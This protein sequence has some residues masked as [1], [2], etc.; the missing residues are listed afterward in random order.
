MRSFLWP[1]AALLVLPS[2]GGS[3][4]PV[5][6]PFGIDKRPS[7]PTCLAQPRP[8]VNTGV[9]LQRQWSTLTFQEPIFLL[10]APGD[11]NQWFVVQREGKVR[12]FAGNATADGQVRD[13]ASITVNS[14]GE[15]GLLGM[16]FHPQWPTRREVYLYYTRTPAAGDPAPVCTALANPP[17]SALISVISRFQ[18]NDGTRLDTAPDEILNVGQPYTNH[19]GGTIE[20]GLDGM[21][22]LGLGDGGAG[23]DPCGSGQNKNSLLGKMLRFDVNAPKGMY[24]IPADNPLAGV[25]GARGEIWSYGHRN[26][27]RWHFDR[28]SGDLWVGDVGQTTWEE[29]DRVVKGGNYGWN[30]C[31]GFHQRGSTTTLCNTPGLSDP[32]VEHPRSEAQSITGGAVYRGSAMPSLVGTYIY[33]DYITGTIWALT[34]DASNKPVPRP[35]ASVPAST[36]VAFGQGNDGEIYTVQITGTISK[37]VPSGAQPPDSFPQLLSQTG[38]VDPKDPTRPAPG[39]IPYDVAAPLWSDGADKQ[40][41]FAIPDGKTITIN[42]DNDWDLPIGSVAMK[43]FSVGGKRVETRLFMRHDD[44]GW[45]GYTYEWNDD[46]KDATLL[47][48]NKLKAL[49]AGATW[50]YPSRTQCIQCH[51]Q[52]AGGT[53]GLETAQLNRDFVYASTNRRS[54]QLA[55]LDHLGMFSAPLPE[56]PDALPQL[57][58]PAGKDPLEARARSYLHG[59]CSHCHRPNGGGQGTMD[60]R[61]AQSL[62]DTSTCNAVNT[63][64]MVG[65][66]TQ[67]IAPGAP[68]DSIVS[69]RLHAT[70]S[71]RM[72]PVA[73][74]IT[75]PLGTKLIDDWIRSL[76]ACP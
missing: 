41:Y 22:Y 47:P 75:D 61:Y 26:P 65:T 7:N 12:A 17:A 42:P 59:N 71:K 18:S 43:T 35:I 45:A 21:L 23:D 68:Q 74:T 5:A 72:P 44:G 64:G 37:L 6:A 46:G 15:G 16:A 2:C 66:A 38:C 11:N 3:D 70:D 51:S 10:Q 69:L 56:P 57:S 24:N 58:D 33:G 25:A 34:Y 52:A 8:V 63:Q 19:K 39:L 36:L 40:R 14:T 49:G 9:T 60:L 1:I 31:E 20:F 4:A 28:V 55:T 32:V 76:T 54:N 30:L 67:L 29:V 27:F 73:V 62:H 48:A 13:F 53:I 50:S